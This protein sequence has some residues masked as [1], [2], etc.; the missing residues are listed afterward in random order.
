MVRLSRFEERPRREVGCEGDVEERGRLDLGRRV[1]GR[2]V[3]IVGAWEGGQ[4]M[5][6]GGWEGEWTIVW[7][8]CGGMEFGWLWEG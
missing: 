2:G 1:R 4:W 5:G 6:L 8:V 7:R 3:G